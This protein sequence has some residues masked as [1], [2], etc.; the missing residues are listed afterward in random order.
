MHFKRRYTDEVMKYT[1]CG[2][3][4]EES[5]EDFLLFSGSLLLSLEWMGETGELFP[6]VMDVGVSPKPNSPSAAFSAK[7][8]SAFCWAIPSSN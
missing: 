1:K 7:F 2:L 5:S 4:L 8:V 3:T 6:E